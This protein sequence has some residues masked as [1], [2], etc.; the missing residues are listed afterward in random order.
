MVLSVAPKSTVEP[1][2][3][4]PAERIQATKG[5]GVGCGLGGVSPMPTQ[6]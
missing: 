4:M 3:V 6:V 2:V 1:S 5:V